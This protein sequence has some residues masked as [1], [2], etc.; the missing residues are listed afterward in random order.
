LNEAS[1]HTNRTFGKFDRPSV[2]VIIHMKCDRTG[3]MYYIILKIGANSIIGVAGG[4][5]LSKLFGL[6][7]REFQN[8]TIS[9]MSDHEQPLFLDR[10]IFV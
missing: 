4:H 2:S 5:R 8:Y 3:R 1:Y 9:C 6:S 7:A 10:N